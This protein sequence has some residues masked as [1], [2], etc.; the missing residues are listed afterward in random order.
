MTATEFTL[1]GALASDSFVDWICRRARLLDLKGWVSRQ[2]PD[3]MTIVVA[4]PMPLIDAMEMACS[5]GPV[6]VLVD[7]VER[8][9]RDLSKLPNGFSVR[10][11]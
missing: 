11:R 1:V 3:L 6:D 5:L 9:P 4:G 7:R 2:G 8:R 10:T